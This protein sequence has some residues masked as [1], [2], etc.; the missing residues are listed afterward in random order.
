MFK[1]R[2]LSVLL[3]SSSAVY[4]TK[5]VLPDILIPTKHSQQKTIEMSKFV[6]SGPTIQVA[7]LLDT[8]GSMDGLIQ[9]AKSKI[10]NIIN[11][12]SKANKSNK[13]VTL[14]VGLFE[15]G[16][17]SISKHEGFLQML[18]P[19]GNDLDLL[20]EKLFSLR[21][22]GG[23][24][25]AGKVILESINRMQWSDHK[26]DLKLII[27]AGNE[28]FEQGDIPVDFSVKKA[29]DNNIIVN[30]VFCGDYDKG[31]D[32]GW[33]KGAENSGGKY[34]NIEQNK[35]IIRIVT[36][37]DELI[38][39]L[40]NKLNNTYI[41]YGIQS[42]A[43]K[44]RQLAQDANA[45]KESRA[46]MVDRS[47]SKASSNYKNDSWDVTSIYENDEASAIKLAKE[48]S[49]HFK[50]MSDDEIRSAIE[51]KVKERNKLKA[52][53]SLLEEK[54][55]AFID[56]NKDTKASDFGSVLLRNVKEQAEGKGYIFKK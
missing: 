38:I 56:K 41:G 9:Q 19:L 1:K 21:T 51:T 3:L 47:I 52:E 39:L 40:G 30:T 11:E 23:E 43:K 14:Q 2:L 34:L 50:G 10:W 44:A 37:Y 16:K 31:I 24:E 6:R 32:L 42:R 5:P 28:S 12:L 55:A 46:M 4:A 8:S 13:D 26:D 7:I 15:Y 48:Q 45:S 53:I 33:K 25:Y 29:V 20:S 49:T 54:R 22:D 27:I 18:L 17:Q 35:Q 36:P